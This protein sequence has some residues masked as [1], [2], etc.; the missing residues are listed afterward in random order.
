MSGYNRTAGDSLAYHHLS[1]FTTKDNDNDE[2]SGN[3]AIYLIGAWWYHRCDYSNLNGRYLTHNV[4]GTF[5]QQPLLFNEIKIK[6]H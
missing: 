5:S 1:K 3:C 2:Y 6:A 4:W